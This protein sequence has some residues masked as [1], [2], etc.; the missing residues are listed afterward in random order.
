MNLK[1]KI[2]KRSKLPEKYTTKILFEWDNRKFK[3]KY[4]NFKLGSDCN[5]DNDLS[6]S[7]RDN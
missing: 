6:K 1:V 2:F 3:D 7:R 5:S 4:Y